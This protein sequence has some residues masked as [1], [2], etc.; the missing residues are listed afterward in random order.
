[1]TKFSKLSAEDSRELVERLIKET[2]L[3]AEEAVE[4]VNVMPRTREELRTFTVGWRKLTPT[5]VLDSMLAIL[6]SKRQKAT[7]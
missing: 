1:M 6:S 2:G 7:S 4:V 5:E 3:T